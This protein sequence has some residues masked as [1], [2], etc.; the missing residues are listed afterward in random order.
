LRPIDNS[1]VIDTSKHAHKI[2]SQDD[3]TIYIRREKGIEKQ[4]RKICIK[5][6]LPLYYQFNQNSNSPKFILAKA[7]TKES[8]S[9]NI[10]DQI[11][12]E[13]K[14]IVKNIKREDKGKSGCVTIS[15]IDEEE[16][17]LEAVNIQ[18]LCNFLIIIINPYSLK[19][20]DSEFVLRK[21][22]CYRNTIGKKRHE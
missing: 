4:H 18:N 17:E 16:E 1:R 7:L 9:S 13:S 3:E 12:I 22:S 19:A 6:S 8:S 20:R 11:I 2:T 10:Y 5:C 21:C 15:T 14:K